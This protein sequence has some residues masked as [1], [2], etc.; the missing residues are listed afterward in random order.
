MGQDR[1]TLDYDLYVVNV[2]GTGLI[3]LTETLG[4]DG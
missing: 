4:S 2:D 1:L 3:R